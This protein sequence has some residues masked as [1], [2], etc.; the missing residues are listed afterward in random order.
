MILLTLVLA[1][2]GV[3]VLIFVWFQTRSGRKALYRSALIL[4]ASIG[5]SRAVIACT[6]WYVVEHNGGPLQIP[7][8]LMSMFA[9]PEA[10]LLGRTRLATPQLYGKLS[11]LLIAGSLVSIMAIAVVADL[12]R[13]FG[14]RLA[15]PYRMSEDE[16]GATEE[17]IE[18]ISTIKGSEVLGYEGAGREEHSGENSPRKGNKLTD[19]LADNKPDQ[20]K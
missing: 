18:K 8:Y 4:G 11:A 16:K 19:D 9:L 20:M 6:G 17:Q 1:F 3:V 5:L 2:A 12:S 15:H 13:R 14:S 7:A 10:V